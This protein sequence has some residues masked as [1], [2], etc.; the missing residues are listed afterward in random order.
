MTAGELLG[1]AVARLRI[2]PGIDPFLEARVL[3]RRTAGFTDLEIFAFPDRPVAAAAARRFS[4]VVEERRGRVPLAYILREKEFWSIPMSV[5]PAVLIP[6][7]ET[8]LLVERALALAG[9][10]EPLIIEIGTGSGCLAVALAKEL[11]GAR[12]IAT[13][14]SRRALRV[15]EANAARHGTGNIR[16]VA[17]DLFGALRGLGLEGRADLIISNPPYVTDGEWKK[18][19]RD[20]R[21]HEP[22]RALVS[23]PTGLEVIRRLAVGGPRFLKPGSALLLEFGSGQAAAVRGLFGSPWARRETAKDLSGRPRVLAAF[24]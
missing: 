18:L 23:G 6:R 22:R 21:D 17:G 20:V 1:R 9:T 8:E 10:A 11:P 15:A 14:I 12:I 4:R 19:A 24:L 13:D 2:I 16:F 5:S 3:L 7:P